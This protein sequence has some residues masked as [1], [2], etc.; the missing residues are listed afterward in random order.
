MIELDGVYILFSFIF[1]DFDNLT[2]TCFLLHLSLLPLLCCCYHS[3]IT[4]WF[5]TPHFS[6]LSFAQK[7]PCLSKNKTEQLQ[8]K[9]CSPFLVWNISCRKI[10]ESILR[11]MEVFFHNIQKVEETWMCIRRRVDKE[12]ATSIQ[13][14]ITRPWKGR[15]FWQHEWA[16][17]HA[18]WSKSVT[19]NTHKYCPI[20]LIWDNRIP[21]R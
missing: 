14:N 21:R 9:T 10:S 11:L 13:Q 7:C 17:R 6:T 3:S 1:L 15:K 19:K 2:H 16:W 5:L 20:A 4:P 18:R 12:S 8:Q